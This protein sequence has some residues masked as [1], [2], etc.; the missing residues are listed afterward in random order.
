VEGGGEGEA[1]GEGGLGQMRSVERD[2]KSPESH[3]F[4]PP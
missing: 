1:G 4:L 2:Q 3:L